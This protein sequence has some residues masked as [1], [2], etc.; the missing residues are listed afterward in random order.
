MSLNPKTRTECVEVLFNPA[1]L[2]GLDR[3]C[4]SFGIA[5][6][7]FLRG[8]SNNAVRTHGTSQAQ[9]PESRRCP[10]PGRAAGRARGVTT[11]R[12]HL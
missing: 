10:G 3:I 2:S 1:E 7:T 6:S 5:R 9:R 4:Q 8:L 12:R 11:A